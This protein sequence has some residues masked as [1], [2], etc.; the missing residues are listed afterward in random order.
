MR[1]SAI[2]VIWLG[3]A[4]AASA[5]EAR[6]PATPPV[7]APE[8]A[9]EPAVTWGAELDTSSRYIWHGLPYSTGAV[10]WPSAWVSA[11]GLTATL[12]T[13]FDPNYLHEKVT[14]T[15][16]TITVDG[17][18]FNEYDL[19]FA[20]EREIKKK[21]TLT[22]T[23]SRYTYRELKNRD[24]DPGSTSEV[25]ARAAYKAGPGEIFTTHSFDVEKHRGAYYAE[26]GYGVEHEVNPKS[27]FGSTLKVD[28][29]LAFW[30]KFAEKYGVDSD[31]PLG[32][33]TLNVAWVQKLAP[34][35]SIRPHMTLLRLM[36]AATRLQQEQPGFSKTPTFSA[37]IAF[38]LGS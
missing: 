9:P 13:N 36:D 28:G 5:Q 32:P 21:L 3:L 22:G 16:Q 30:S 35:L 8:D 14:R 6:P 18:T 17:P 23:F 26:V 34:Y 38:T 11:K 4:G 37:G 31:G 24:I 1:L 7:A 10:A 27:K 29:S 15:G 2:V 19:T 20:Y 12:W 33:A 25:I